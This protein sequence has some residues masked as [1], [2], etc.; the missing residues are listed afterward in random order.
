MKL[1]LLTIMSTLFFSCGDANKITV[2]GI[3]T[4]TSGTPLQG[5]QVLMVDTMS[6]CAGGECT[7]TTD[8]SGH[9]SQYFNSGKAFKDAAVRKETCQYIATFPNHADQA[10]SFEFCISGSCAGEQSVSTS[11]VL[12]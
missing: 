4:N 7:F 2:S 1:I 6:C 3:V 8:S 12:Q 9:W 5:A 10:G 11:V